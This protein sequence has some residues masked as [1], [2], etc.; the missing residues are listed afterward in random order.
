[1]TKQNIHPWG[2]FEIDDSTGLPVVP[3]GQFWRVK[4]PASFSVYSHVQLRRGTRFGSKL[5]AQS[6]IEASEL[7]K[8]GILSSAAYIVRYQ[9]S[10]KPIDKT[11][12]GDY[13]P[14]KLEV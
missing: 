14:K 5:V 2:E 9:A 4:Q 12:Y 11:L 7:T 3:E 1:M 13:P 8:K 10:L 6:P